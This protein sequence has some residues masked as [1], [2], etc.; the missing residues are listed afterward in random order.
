MDLG[1][2]VWESFEVHVR[3]SWDSR[4]ET[5]EGDSREG[6]ERREQSWRESFH[7][8]REYIKNHEQSAVRTVKAI[9]ARL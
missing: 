3:K 7:L 6:S 8:L 2:G 1:S 4:E 5:A 9:L